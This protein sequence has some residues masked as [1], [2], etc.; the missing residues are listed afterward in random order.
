MTHSPYLKDIG[1]A[2][3]RTAVALFSSNALQQNQINVKTSYL[4]KWGF[5]VYID[6]TL[7]ILLVST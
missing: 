2:S 7:F 3:Y 5:V 4:S 6:I 1:I